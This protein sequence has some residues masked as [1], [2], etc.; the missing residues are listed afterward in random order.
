VNYFLSTEIDELFATD[1]PT[2]ART[3]NAAG[4]THFINS[5]NL[6]KYTNS[7]NN[8]NKMS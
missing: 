6:Y 7:N 1:R 2:S 5:N 3:D 4:S 8:V